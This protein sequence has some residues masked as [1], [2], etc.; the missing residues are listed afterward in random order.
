MIGD[1]QMNKIFC[2]LLGCTAVCIGTLGAVLPILPTFPF[3]MLAAWYFSRSSE[4]MNRWFRNTRLYRDNLE[5]Y[6]SRRGMTWK[7]KIRIMI[8]LTL[9][10]SV[11]LLIMG[12]RGIVLGCAILAFVWALHI[13]LFCFGIKTIS[14]SKKET[15]T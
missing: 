10:M 14:V 1:N 6:I 3:L 13:F 5:D 2:I 8:T 15:N 11:G 12:S 4:K 9:L 7:A